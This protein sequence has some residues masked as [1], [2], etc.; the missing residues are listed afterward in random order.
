MSL[1]KPRRELSPQTRTLIVAAHA[2]GQTYKEIAAA[3]KVRR[4][5][6]Q[7]VV[8]RYG[9]RDTAESGRRSGRP[10]V[11]SGRDKRHIMRLVAA[12]P[13]ISAR[14]VMERV[15]LKCSGHTVSRFLKGEGIRVSSV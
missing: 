9:G 8:A 13:F 4:G 2:N 7:G 15:G 10:V 11:L 14:E 5:T 6:I 3:Y 1:K 12:D